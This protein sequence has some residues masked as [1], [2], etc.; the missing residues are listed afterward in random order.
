[1]SKLMPSQRVTETEALLVPTRRRGRRRGSDRG[2]LVKFGYWWW[3]LP[4][5]VLI[6]GIH[7]AATSVGGFFAFTD[8]SGIG[9]FEVIGLDNFTRILKDPNQLLALGNTLQL[10]GYPAT[11]GGCQG[12]LGVHM[13]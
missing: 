10:T 3:A 1:M 12:S 2:R 4:G 11:M 8:W 5:V 7:Y 9:A 13:Q 6:L